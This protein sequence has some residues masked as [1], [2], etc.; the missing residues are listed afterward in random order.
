MEAVN[1]KLDFVLSAQTPDYLSTFAPQVAA[2][3]KAARAD[4][5]G[6][7]E[8][9]AYTWFNRL[10]ALRYLDARGWHP[11]RCRVLTTA[12]S[13][14][15]QPE[16]LKLVRSA[17]LPAELQQH[18]NPAR[19]ND[20]IDG[21]IPSS[22]PQGEV[23]RHLVLASC[24]YYHAL[25][26]DLFE[27]LDD[28]TEL[29]LPDDVLTEHSVVQG[30]RT[31][32]TDTDCAEVEVLGWLYQFY[33]SEKKDEVMARKS[34]VPSEDIP[35][36]TQLF[37]P[38]W[39]VRYLVENSLGRLWLLNR[40]NSRLRE[41]MPY[42]IEGQSE[43]D[44]LRITGPEEIRVLDPAVGSGHMLTYAFD[45]LY[46]IY[47]EEGYA[48]SDIPKLI[49]THNLYGLDICPRA[50]QLASLALA[51]KARERSSRALLVEHLVQANILA[52]QD[53]RFE[54]GE[55]EEYSRVL[56]VAKSFNYAV[57]TA[58]RDFEDVASL[59]SL[60]QPRLQL[61]SVRQVRRVVDAAAIDGQLFIRDTHSKVIQVIKQTEYLATRYHVV[62]ANPPYFGPKQM[63]A[64]LK[65]FAK[66]YF[67]DSKTDLY[68]MFM[69]RSF[70]LALDHGYSAM[71]VM[72]SWMFLHSFQALRTKLL[73]TKT[74]LSMAHLGPRA[75]S[76]I[77]GEVVTVAAT[78]FANAANSQSFAT[79]CRL[80]AGGE[81]EKEL[82]FRNGTARYVGV[83][84]K[85][86]RDVPG[87]PIAYW[88]SNRLRAAF[89]KTLLFEITISDGQNITANNA[90]FVREH[91]EVSASKVGRER[92]W[93]PYAKGGPFRRWF[94]NI[95]SVID[96]S[97]PARVHYRSDSSCRIIPE[98]LWY[99][100]GV[101]WSRV[102]TGLQGFRLLPADT[103]F[104]K[105]GSSI[106]PAGNTSVEFLLGV[107]NSPVTQIVLDLLNPSIDL[108]V[109]D[110]RNVPLPANVNPELVERLV[111][112]LISHSQADW[113]MHETSLDFQ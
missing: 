67:P 87:S 37:T 95:E 65:E 73:T 98:Y 10:A 18:I 100:Q 26:P 107:L 111:G 96:W 44:F 34:T 47:E 23:Y 79:F 7:V 61:E 9:V 81:A 66:G 20:L 28:E 49:L 41:K 19:L 104:D 83:L 70:S 76:T 4:R 13:D 102:G 55:I 71:I 45:L 11:F 68:A 97:E 62:V 51:L 110:V 39:I 57:V 108:Q 59:G 3:R 6:L 60:L 30:F 1:R 8:R 94:G 38:H 86:F 12:S 42:Y 88:I 99:C 32:I 17:A 40:P 22:D 64:A 92:K 24:R 25:L 77:T 78:C 85:S 112:E 35:A 106:F 56:D 63:N 75:F 53:V 36:V 103:T 5:D 21:R 89:K 113:S 93:L 74:I 101:T 29:L 27:R 58:F 31:Q 52:L 105:V 69:E 43:T 80:V 48:P 50:A 46:A 90:R 2:L 33:I 54:T 14:E 15:T 109:K 91:W 82:G 84:Q 72:Q 16:I